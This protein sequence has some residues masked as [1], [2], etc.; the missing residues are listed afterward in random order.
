M[1]ENIIKE[2][3]ATL[4]PIELKIIDQ[5]HLH[6]G[7]SANNGGGHFVIHISS[8]SFEGKSR[9]DRHR[10]IYQLMQDLI[11]QSIHALSIKAMSPND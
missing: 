10:I 7:H 8:L 2:R 5:S 3:L 6:K 9:M 11:P 1:L 4:N